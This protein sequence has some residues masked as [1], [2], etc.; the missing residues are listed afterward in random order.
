MPHRVEISPAA[1]R[2]IRQLP[3]A[4]RTRLEPVILAL[5]TQPRPPGVR[6]I[7]GAERAYRVRVGDYRGVYEVHDAEALVV[8]LHIGRRTERTYR[9]V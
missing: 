3:E 7:Q 8:V 4:V 5:A 6:K 1:A 2:D 9:Q